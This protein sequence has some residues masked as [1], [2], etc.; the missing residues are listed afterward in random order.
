M[1]ILYTF[2]IISV[3]GTLL[4][5][6]YNLSN[7]N[8][9]FAIFSAVNESVW[10]H[11]KLLLTPIFLVSTIKYILKNQNN[12]F[13]RLFLMLITSILLIIIFEYL[14]TKY[15]KKYK[16]VFYILS[17]YVTTLVV[18][19]I[20]HIFINIKPLYFLNKI[21]IFLCLIMF[22]MYL[23]FTIFPPKCRIFKDPLTGKYGIF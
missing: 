2:I 13:I 20:E 5:F 10:E 1:E 9:A 4:H 23:T 21:S 14:I 6:T 19:L 8:I 18:T 11:I 17:F 12:Y 3:L 15:I 16:S 22:I 7:K